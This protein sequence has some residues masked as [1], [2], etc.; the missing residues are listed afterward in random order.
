MTRLE[1]RDML[2]D[3]VGWKSHPDYSISEGNTTS[4]GGR[5]FQD[6]HSFITIETICAL[7][8]NSKPSA[9]ELNEYLKSLKEQVV[10]QVVDD[11][12]TP[13][14]FYTVELEKEPAIFDAAIQKRMAI[15]LGELIWTTTRSNRIERISKEYAQQIF[16]DVNGD[17]NFPSKISISHGYK[18]EIDW[19]KDRFDTQDTL[20]VVTLG[21]VDYLDIDKDILRF[22]E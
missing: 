6:A 15:K 2:I 22:N 3:R 19:I 14:N 16:F 4:T 13:S 7:M 9:L 21:T 20:D 18:K 5:Y 12:F 1:L 17:P 8:R 11:A 10:L